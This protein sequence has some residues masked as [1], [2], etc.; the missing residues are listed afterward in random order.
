[1]KSLI[2]VILVSLSTFVAHG[3]DRV[4]F[5]GL[6]E[7]GRECRVKYNPERH[8]GL[9]YLG[10]DMTTDYGVWQEAYNIVESSDHR[11]VAEGVVTYPSDCFK[12]PRLG[13]KVYNNIVVDFSEGRA[14]L[15]TKDCKEIG[16]YCLG[17]NTYWCE[18]E[19]KYT[20]YSSS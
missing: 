13:K 4:L 11:V 8:D 17:T 2:T 14:E 3:S 10:W 7:N 5:E 6:D 9:D 16:V 12:V 20:C 1:M 18:E 15:R 19:I